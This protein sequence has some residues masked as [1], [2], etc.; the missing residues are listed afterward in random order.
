MKRI[1]TL[2]IILLA[3]YALLAVGCSRE[4]KSLNDE[5]PQ[6]PFQFE[7]IPSI[8]GM[9]DQQSQPASGS[10]GS[11]VDVE[12]TD[13]STA[14][15]PEPVEVTEEVVAPE[16]ESVD[17]LITNM[18]TG[19]RL[20]IQ[21][22]DYDTAIQY[23][24]GVLEQDPDYTRALYNLSLIYRLTDK[25]DQAIEYGLK[26]VESD[27]DML[28]VHQNLGYA[29][30]AAGD[31]DS[32]IDAYEEELIRHPD[33]KPLAVIASNLCIIYT[34][35]EQYE[36]AIDAAIT[37]INLDPGLH[38]YHV[39][40]GDTYM[41][42]EAFDQAIEAYKDALELAP[43]STDIMVAIG[44]AYWESGD[45]VKAQEYYNQ[46]ISLDEK[47]RDTIPAERLES[48]EPSEAPES[49]EQVL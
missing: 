36:N 20:A 49:G 42:T 14:T 25:I 19:G 11:A 39:L 13:I 23:F 35:R 22:G 1:V 32:A 27:P 47:V 9:M 31:I 10:Q 37:A 38:I 15:E 29:Y 40:L 6:Q 7:H 12:S 30:E 33:A 21:E 34:D 8:A 18:M 28:Y 2:A 43:D 16:E 3:A 4:L 46:A 5:R 48:I 44:D 17:P 24:E 26:A 45:R 41:K